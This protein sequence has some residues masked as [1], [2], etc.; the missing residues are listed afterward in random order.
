MVYRHTTPSMAGSTGWA[1][2]RPWEHIVWTWPE[3]MDLHTALKNLHAGRCWC[4]KPSRNYEWWSCSTEHT[5]LWWQQ[6]ERW[7][8]VRLEVIDR[9]NY[10]CQM[11]GHTRERNMGFSRYGLLEVDHIVVISN[12]GEFWN[13]DN[14]RTLCGECHRKKTEEDRRKLAVRRK[15]KRNN[16]PQTLGAFA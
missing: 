12:G 13:R 3:G 8:T 2:N 10:T 5:G 9:D 6:F 4:G 1:N 7:G 16:I 11:C 14:M 15:H